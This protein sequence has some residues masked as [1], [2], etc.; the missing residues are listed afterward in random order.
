MATRTKSAN[1][2]LVGTYSPDFQD[3]LTAAS[4]SDEDIDQLILT[5][6]AVD[7]RVIDGHHEAE[8]ILK[9]APDSVL[10]EH[11]DR[12]V[13]VQEFSIIELVR[14]C[15][16][17]MVPRCER[18]LEARHRIAGTTSYVLQQYIPGRQI[19]EA[20]PTLGCW[21]RFRVA[22][23]IRFYIY[24]LRRL[25]RR[26]GPPPFPGPLSDDG[27]P[28]ICTGR[29][30]TEDDCAGPFSSYHDMSYWYD[31]RLLLVRR[32]RREGLNAAPFDDSVPL[33][34]THKDLHDANII[35]GD[36]GNLWIIDWADA[37]WYPEW[38]EGASMKTHAE[39][40]YLPD[41]PLVSWRA[42]IPFMVG[43][44]EK[45]GQL[46]FIRAINFSLS[47]VPAHIADFVSFKS[48][49][50]VPALIPSRQHKLP[51]ID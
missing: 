41:S 30:F 15:T 32:F 20:W 50:N 33:V 39:V 29:L 27:T 3:L 21:T 35:I 51:N 14:R 8:K 4:M 1:A 13:A 43:D 45:L 48:T 38:F 28:R 22:L 24:Q 17:V 40:K 2:Y 9:I 10:K 34:I 7:N 44:C 6:E 49:L 19:Y 47:G 18:V 23:T 37:G 36:D 25:S 12:D 31:N 11:Y 26:I 46:P 16:S 5:S 42:W